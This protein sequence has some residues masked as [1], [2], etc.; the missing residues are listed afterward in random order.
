MWVGALLLLLLL[1][2]GLVIAIALFVAPE[3]TVGGLVAAVGPGMQ[4]QMSG[5]GMLE[6]SAD[7]AY[8]RALEQHTYDVERMLGRVP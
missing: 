6:R 7:E 8:L 1:V 5:D 4:A 2:G 3:K